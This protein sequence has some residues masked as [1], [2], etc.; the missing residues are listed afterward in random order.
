MFVLEE[1]SIILSPKTA[2]LEND[3]RLKMLETLLYHAGNFRWQAVKNMYSVI[4]SEIEIGIRSWEH[5]DREL[6]RIESMNLL[7]A[8][9][10]KQQAGGNQGIARYPPS[11]GPFLPNRAHGDRGN[12][13]D[14]S[15]D[16]LPWFC[17]AYNR[18][19]CTFNEPHVSGSQLKG[20]MRVLQHICAVCWTK[21]KKKQFTER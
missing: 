11:D 1:L 8:P 15:S 12:E 20:K 3:G 9:A 17:S 5:W 19:A 16:S 10:T 18:G 13:R 6:G 2:G 4:L 14:V 7:C 21:G